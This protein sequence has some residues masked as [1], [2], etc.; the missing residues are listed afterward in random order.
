MEVEER[1]AAKTQVKYTAIA[2]KLKD[3]ETKV[4]SVRGGPADR[5]AFIKQL[6]AQCEVL[7]KE[8]RA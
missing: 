2:K 1:R 7:R 3:L 5:V 8:W 4:S 6:R